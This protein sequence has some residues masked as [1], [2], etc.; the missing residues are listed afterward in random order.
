MSFAIATL[1][2]GLS[3]IFL[4]PFKLQILFR[5]NKIFSKYCDT[6]DMFTMT[7]VSQKSISV[8]IAIL[9][10]GLHNDLV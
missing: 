1:T 3:G 2:T 10:T 5:K 9:T 4:I 8:A 7:L 6:N